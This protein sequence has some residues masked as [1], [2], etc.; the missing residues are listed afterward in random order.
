[1]LVLLDH[2]RHWVQTSFHIKKYSDILDLI[3]NNQNFL[4]ASPVSQT[5]Q[6]QKYMSHCPKCSDGTLRHIRLC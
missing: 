4:S 2:C 6:E 1:M 3:G 5:S